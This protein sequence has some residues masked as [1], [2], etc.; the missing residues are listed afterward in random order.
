[1]I[2]LLL[3]RK[4]SRK[5][6]KDEPARTIPCPHK[7]CNKLFRDNSAMRKHLHTHGPRVHVCAECGKSFVESG[8]LKRHQLV[9]TGEKPFQVGLGLI[10]NKC[11]SLNAD[12]SL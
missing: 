1:M 6:A 9:H 7:G 10:I 12:A 5:E 11:M 3:V 2:Y 4:S 8:K